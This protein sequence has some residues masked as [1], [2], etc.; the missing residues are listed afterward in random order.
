MLYNTICS[1]TIFIS[2]LYTVYMTEQHN[3]ILFYV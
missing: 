2:I 1:C 3:A